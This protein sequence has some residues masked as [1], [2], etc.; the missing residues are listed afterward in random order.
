MSTEQPT[1][2]VIVPTLNEAKN[3]PLIFSHLPLRSIHEVI[4]VDGRSTD[5]TV[6]VARRL[7]PSIKVALEPAPGKG[8]AL[9]A[10][11]RAAS[12]DILI[13][14]DADG[15]NDPR[16]LP[17]FVQALLE[18]ADFAKGSRFAPHGGTSDMP[19][20]RQMGNAL[21]VRLVNV[22]FSATFTDLCYGYHAF[23]RY[24]LDSI[25]LE[26]VDGFEIDTALYL[27]ALRE[28]LRVIE[29]PSFEGYRF[30][31]IGKLQTLPDGWRV[32][33]TILAEWWVR[34]RA[35]AKD[36][37]L[38]FRGPTPAEIEA[39]QPRLR[40]R[41]AP[42]ARNGDPALTR[43]PALASR[44]CVEPAGGL[45]LMPSAG[46]LLA[47]QH[48]LRSLL[49]TLLRDSLLTLDAASGSVVLMDERG[50]ALDSLATFQ[51]KVQTLPSQATLDLLHGGLAG[52]IVANRQPAL[53]TNTLTDPRWL[54][55]PWEFSQSRARSAVGTP[56]LAGERVAGVLIL[57]R[58]EAGQFA[59]ADAAS[60]VS[61]AAGM[62]ARSPGLARNGNGNGHGRRGAARMH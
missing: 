49:E 52:W 24:C 61:L 25:D 60:L 53:V 4:L 46:D 18:G 37:H 3:L 22:L 51:G 28:R 31:G 38:G 13:V 19:R 62:D 42:L 15:S 21:F 48:N 34:L 27:R 17:R 23:W 59:E 33:R 1:V 7:L 39:A 41:A 36:L 55:R 47:V 50:G 35:P 32:L 26:D 14:M 30:H 54:C 12:G 20:V 6:E 9:R 44:L 40:G 43:T 8:A 57:A 2:S 45:T 5:E 56:L 16:E 10:G 11:Y 58:P 29:V